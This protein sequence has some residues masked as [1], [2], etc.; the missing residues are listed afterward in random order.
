MR[1]T[2]GISLISS[3]FYTLPS[4]SLQAPSVSLHPTSTPIPTYHPTIDYF[5]AHWW[6]MSDPPTYIPSAAPVCIDN[7]TGWVDDSGNGCDWYEETEL[8][9]CPVYRKKYG[10]K[11][12][13]ALD[14]CCICKRTTDVSEVVCFVD[15]LMF[16]RRSIHVPFSLFSSFILG[17]ESSPN[18][19][20]NMVSN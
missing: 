11:A 2:W 8:P 7:T 15:V 19:V 1:L 16:C 3:L 4:P 20:A 10:V 14:H 6:F 5:M 18:Y 13:G 9:G 17:S 12:G